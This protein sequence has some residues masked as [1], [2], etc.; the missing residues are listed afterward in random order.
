MN[1]V[2]TATD[3]SVGYGSHVVATVG[4]FQVEAGRTMVITGPNGSGKTTLLKTIAGLLPPV[5]GSLHPSIGTGEG[6]AVFVHSVPFLF[7]G[8]VRMNMLL[9]T[10]DEQRARREL[11]RLKGDDLW[12]RDVRRLSSGQRQRVAIARALAAGPRLLLLDEPEGGLDAAA[13]DDWR[14]VLSE[15][16]ETGSPCIA[17][18]THSINAFEGM[19]VERLSL[20]SP[21]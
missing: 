7:Q 6:G 18:A 9:S 14:R 16:T 3:L 19:P 12:E 13:I 4:T 17:L 1:V 5:G 2:V 20:S 11:R 21:Q 15:A 10:A 8:T